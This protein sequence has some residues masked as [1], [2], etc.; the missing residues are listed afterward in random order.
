M[1]RERLIRLALLAYPEGIREQRGE[2]MAAT[3]LDSSERSRRVLVTELVALV[4]GGLRAPTPP[5]QR[6]GVWRFRADACCLVGSFGLFAAIT[7][8][9]QPIV[10][11]HL[12]PLHAG[13]H[14][15]GGT[16]PAWDIALLVLALTLALA[17][18]DRTA[19]LLG[20]LWVALSNPYLAL[21]G[22]GASGAPQPTWLAAVG[23][24]DLPLLACLLV[25]VLAPRRR[26]FDP[27]R[28]LWLAFLPAIPWADVA[29][30]PGRYVVFAALLLAV[31]IKLRRDQR[32]LVALPIDIACWLAGV[33]ARS[34]LVPGQTQS[35]I[36]FGVLGGL[37]VACL[38]C[39]WAGSAIADP[40]RLTVPPPA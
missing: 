27:R 38:A 22:T 25:M 6:I 29:L 40:R 39:A 17:G 36:L 7:G 14:Y 4:L 10:E 15:V 5:Q 37:C 32:M 26:A 9:L 35:P 8:R 34:I 1:T 16:A 28:L 24:D 13:A 11:R 3:V 19:G 2:E 20:L 18:R 12:Q 21:A 23:A 31:L 30:T 33:A